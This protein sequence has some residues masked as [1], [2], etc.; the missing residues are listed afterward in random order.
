MSFMD[1]LTVLEFLMIAGIL[2]LDWKIYKTERESLSTEREN[3]ELYRTYFQ[4]RIKWYKTRSQ[5]SKPVPQT[6]PE[7]AGPSPAEPDKTVEKDLDPKP[8]A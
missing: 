8:L 4:E 2:W 6:I 5:R 1:V 3:L 7:T